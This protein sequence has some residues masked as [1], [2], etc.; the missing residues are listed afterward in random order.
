MWNEARHRELK[1]RSRAVSKLGAAIERGAIVRPTVCE[2]C[3]KNKDK[4]EGHH[5]DYDKP[6][7][8][9][10]L[11]ISCHRKLH[12]KLDGNGEVII[13]IRIKTENYDFDKEKFTKE[14]EKLTEQIINDHFQIGKFKK[15]YRNFSAKTIIPENIT[16]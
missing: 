8:V 7:D 13:T 12:M 15:V 9:I 2:K 5:F 3:H 6:L 14:V 16:V 4:I 1:K 10:W 11:C